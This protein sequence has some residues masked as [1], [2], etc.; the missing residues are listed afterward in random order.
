MTCRTI[1]LANHRLHIYLTYPDSFSIPNVIMPIPARRW[2]VSRT[3]EAL[4]QAGKSQAD[5]EAATLRQSAL[6]GDMPTLMS[7]DALHQ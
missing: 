7:A 3:A 2:E 4:C 6:Q 1:Y 5:L